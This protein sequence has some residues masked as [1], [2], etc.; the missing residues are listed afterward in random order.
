M[1]FDKQS[2]KPM[3]TQFIYIYIRHQASMEIKWHDGV[4]F[5][6][7]MNSN[8]PLKISYDKNKT[9]ALQIKVTF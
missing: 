6:N 7:E 2:P 8:M 9:N 1:N 5:R 4:I 3:L